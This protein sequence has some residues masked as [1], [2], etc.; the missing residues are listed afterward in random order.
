MANQP[1]AMVFEGPGRPLVR[2][3]L[4]APT[5]APGELLVEVTLS[6]LCGSDLHT[7]AGRR[8]SPTP[9]VLGHEIM[10]RVAEIGPRAVLDQRG[11]V[12]AVGQRVTWSM[13]VS[14]GNC[15]CCRHGLP[16]KC[17][18][19]AKYGHYRL[20][21]GWDL[22]GGLAS[23]VQL[24]AGSNLV[25]LP[26][27]LPDE[28]AAPANCAAA[29]VAAAWRTAGLRAGEVA[30]IHGAGMLG[31]TACAMAVE[32]GA[33]PVVVDPDAARALRAADF[34]ASAKSVLELSDGRGAD[35]AL[36]VS[37]QPE[38]LA[39]GLASLRLGGRAVWV[40]SVFS[41]PPLA[42]DAEQ[43]VRRVLTISGLHNY[44]PEDLLTAVEFLDRAA[45]RFPFAALTERV[46]PLSEANVAFADA[47]AS[48]AVR[49][50]V[51]PDG[52]TP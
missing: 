18:R 46:Y 29:T 24:L 34:G 36:D 8:E 52:V 21:A 12:I 32:L 25:S 43:V 14:C 7:C 20:D 31:L 23:H 44:T 33:T 50:G 3:E 5:L 37:G 15:F 42:L 26:D 17:A 10:G 40:G 35:V 9:G 28:V 45:A 49:I 39:D 4:A 41:A 6:T 22:H 13:M 38:A 2:R 30:L 1:W 11:A 27:S 51:R 19:V 48:R 16:Q 47:T